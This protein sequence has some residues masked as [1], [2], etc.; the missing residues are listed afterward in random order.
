VTDTF[1]RSSAD[2]LPSSLEGGDGNADE[3]RGNT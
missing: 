3:A 2:D 1:R